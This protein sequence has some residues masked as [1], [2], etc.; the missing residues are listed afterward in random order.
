MSKLSDSLTVA[1][2]IW[3]TWAIRSQSL[4]C[5]KQSEQIA[6]SRSF[7][8]SEMSEWSNEQFPSPGVNMKTHCKLR[9]KIQ[10]NMYCKRYVFHI[11]SP[12][13]PKVTFLTFA[14]FWRACH[15]IYHESHLSYHLDL[16]KNQ[17]WWN[18]TVSRNISSFIQKYP[19]PLAELNFVCNFKGKYLN[20][21][22]QQHLET[23]I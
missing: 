16:Q 17:M 13:Y 19:S 8:Y 22:T 14:L 21:K 5:L 2:L 3:A 15:I 18:Q 12:I 1:L 4:I 6:H 7:V 11:W 23:Q 10:K 20:S 9:C